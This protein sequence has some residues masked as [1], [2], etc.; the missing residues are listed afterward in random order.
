MIFDSSILGLTSSLNAPLLAQIDLTSNLTNIQYDVLNGFIPESIITLVILILCFVSFAVKPKFRKPLVINLSVIGIVLAL[1]SLIYSFVNGQF[2]TDLFSGMFVSDPLSM[3]FRFIMLL[4]ALTVVGLSTGYFEKTYRFE[5][6]YYILLLTATLGT[7]LMAGA[8]DLIMAFVAMETLGISS[9]LLT[10]Y[11][12]KDI[13]N[14]EAALKYLVIGAASSGVLLYGMSFLYGF[15]GST[16]FN[17]IAQHISPNSMNYALIIPLITVIAGIGYKMAVA[18]FHVW[19]PDVYEGAPTPFTAFL[20][21]ASKA[22]GF[23]LMIRIMTI[24]F[25]VNAPEWQI[26]VA[27]LCVL[28]MFIG[29]LT[30]LAQTNIK[31]LLAYSSIAHAGYITIGLVV[32]SENSLSSLIYYIIVYLFMQLGAWCAILIFFNQTGSDKIEDYSGLAHKRPVL[33]LGFSLCLL[34]LAGIPITAGFF[35]KFYLFQAAILGGNEYL[36]LIIIALINSAISLYYYINV[37]KLMVINKQSNVVENLNS[38]EEQAISP[39][40]KSLSFVLGFTVSAVILIGIFASPIIELSK[41]SVEQLINY[42][43]SIA[44][45]YI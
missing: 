11:I 44:K 20:S 23:V 28:S 43:S 12:R 7:M 8:N 9:Y 30:A 5:S 6:E 15:S 35:A 32:F 36:W 22:A 13:K 1:F 14:N 24:V 33:A 16:H 25:F 45:L 40:S 26:I 27:V 2:Y 18:P 37:I 3:I 42:R 38:D 19:S 31:R 29:N 34:S 4:S 21:V 41:Y 10:G 39:Q 17:L